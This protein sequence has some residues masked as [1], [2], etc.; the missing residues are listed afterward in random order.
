MKGVP[1]SKDAD[2]FQVCVE[3]GIVSS[4]DYWTKT[5]VEGKQCAGAF[6]ATVIRRIAERVPEKK[7]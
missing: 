5:A 1:S 3:K 4:P 2:L 6:V 7:R